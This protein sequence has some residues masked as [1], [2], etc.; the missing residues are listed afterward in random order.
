M[1]RI[2]TSDHSLY[3]AKLRILFRHKQIAFEE[4]PPPGGGGSAEYL[5]IVPSGNIPA[6][7]DGDLVLTDSEAIA[8]YLEEKYP[9]RPM[10]PETQ[11]GRALSRERSRFAD[12]RLEPALRLTFPHVAPSSR[13]AG[14][15]N[16]AHAII[17]K[18]LVALAVMLDWSP[19]PRDHLWM[20]DCG[21]IVT[22]EW[23]ALFEGPVIAALDWPEAVT[24]YRRQMLQHAAVADEMTAYR[25]EMLHY[26]R[27]KGAL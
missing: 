20:G 9:E 23:I 3:C 16:A 17:T 8:E 4:A 25:P 10:L 18:R 24:T 6:L 7:V 26:M 12:T 1:L 11:V 21:T 5:S 15:I 19:L 14:A 2:Y 27:E 22:L 13:D